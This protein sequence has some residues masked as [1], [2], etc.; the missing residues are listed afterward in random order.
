MSDI[1]KKCQDCKKHY[2]S[3]MVTLEYGHDC[4]AYE[5]KVDYKLLHQLAEARFRAAEEYIVNIVPSVFK[6]QCG[7]YDDLQAAIKNYE[8]QI[9]KGE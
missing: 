6:E 1:I 8:E 4:I 3:C 7:L 5:S 2:N 9:K